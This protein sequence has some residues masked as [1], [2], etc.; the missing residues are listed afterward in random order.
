M[1]LTNPLEYH[2]YVKVGEGT[3]NLNPKYKEK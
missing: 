3:Y 1:I 2:K